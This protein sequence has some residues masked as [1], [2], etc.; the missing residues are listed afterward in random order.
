MTHQGAA[1]DA[2]NV[3]TCLTQ[4]RSSTSLSAY[5]AEL[6]GITGMNDWFLNK[7]DLLKSFA[8][9][10]VSHLPGYSIAQRR[11]ETRLCFGRD[12]VALKVTDDQLAARVEFQIHR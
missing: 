2:A 6:D 10:N 12:I 9:V 5:E 1:R 4:R 8:A 3:H 7:K 11:Q